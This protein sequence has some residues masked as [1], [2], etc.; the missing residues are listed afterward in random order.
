[1]LLG[2]KKE[3]KI[4]EKVYKS[5]KAEF[6]TIYGRRRIGKTYLVRKLFEQD[7]NYFEIIGVKDTSLK[8]QLA[9]FARSLSSK[10]LDSISISSPNNW[11]EAF[12]LLTS[13]IQKIP[14]KE[15]IILFF[16]ELPWLASKKSGF[17]QALDYIWNKEWSKM[18]N[19]LLITCGS[20]ASWMLDNLINAK[21]GLHNRITCRILLEPFKLFEVGEF[22]KALGLKFTNRQIIETYMVFGGV[23][24]YL[25][26][27]DKRLSLA[28]N[29]DNICFN[30]NG[31]LADE[32]P[33]LFKSLFDS[34]ELNL[35]ITRI[36]SRHHYGVSRD[37]LIKKLGASSGGR[38]N[39]RL[40]ELE[41]TGFIRS[42]YS[43][44]KKKNIHYKMIDEYS[45]FY[46]KWIEPY[47]QKGWAANYW[48]KQIGSQ[49]YYSWSGYA[50][51]NVCFKH[52]DE[53]ESTL[54]IEN[55]VT[56]RSSWKSQ[57]KKNASERAA[58]VDLLF[59]RKDNVVNLCEIKFT[60]NP[61]DVSKDEAIILKN[62]I[63][64]FSEEF[65][66]KQVLLTIISS[67][68]MKNN[69]WTEDLVDSVVKM[70]DIL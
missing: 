59:E 24:Y 19:I 45:L 9:N 32:F 23:P 58:Q 6:V 63:L 39:H 53:I 44:E 51:E 57:V 1:M 3:R 38:I 43:Y 35:E 12:H 61:Y 41:S 66:K 40:E 52:I 42:F 2:R 56:A 20:A 21:G 60:E 29:I 17:L 48:M 55:L 16:D 50:F 46:F 67:A 4:F 37:E 8:E 13:L 54:G 33:K 65:P 26:E 27:L 62:K 28:Q 25:S 34:S 22:I 49:G 30:K 47:A 11:I 69:I 70:E 5:D 10:Y 31:L 36:I 7:K 64:R 18:P 68:G 14:T 15:K